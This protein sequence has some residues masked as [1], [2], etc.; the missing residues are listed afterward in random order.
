[1]SLA[2]LLPRAGQHGLLRR[3]R[4]QTD[5]PAL[6]H[7]QFVTIW[8]KREFLMTR[9]GGF[10]K[11]TETKLPVACVVDRQIFPL[12][13]RGAEVEPDGHARGHA[14]SCDY[15]RV[16]CRVRIRVSR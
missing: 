10:H 4:D 8:R 6:N 16:S 13:I 2:E 5:M 7:C 12:K 1:M 14:W 11:S 9:R 3:Q 15:K